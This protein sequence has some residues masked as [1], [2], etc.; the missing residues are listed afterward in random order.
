MS[1]PTST[2]ERA[3]S[4]VE[5]A[6][7]ESRALRGGLAESIAGGAEHFEGDDKTLLKFHGIYEQYDRDAKERVENRRHQYMVRV[8]IPGGALTAEQYLAL[9]RLADRFGGANLRLTSR[10]GVQFHGL[11]LAEL[12]PALRELD[13]SLLTTLA[14]C[15]D[16]RRNVVACPAPLDDAAHRQAQATARAIAE[17]LRPR[18]GAYHQIWLDGERVRFDDPAADLG[19][20]D[21]E[22]F[23][24]ETY[25]PRKFKIGVALENDNCIDLYTQDA[26]LLGLVE[27]GQVIGWNVVA[28]GGLGITHG[29]SDTFARLA[30][31]IGFV[32]FERGVE[33]IHAVAEVFRDHGDRSDRKRARLKYV[34]ERWGVER[35]RAEVQARIGFPLEDPRPVRAGEQEDH[36]GI[37]SQHAEEKLFFLG[38]YV[39][40]GRV[41]DLPGR[42]LRTAVREVVE[43]FRPGVRLTAQQSLLFTDLSRSEIAAV[44]GLLAERGVVAAKELSP[45]RRGS[46]ACPALPTCSLALAD[47]E[48][49][50]PQSLDEL[51]REFARLGIDDLPLTVRITGCPNGCARPYNADIGFVGRKPGV[52]HV[53]VGGGLAGDRLADLYAAD[54]GLADFVDVLRPLLEAYR[55]DRQAEESLSDFWQRRA[56]QLAPPAQNA[57]RAPRQLLTG[58]EPVA[59][60]SVLLANE[61]LAGARS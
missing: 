8:A 9:D 11:L 25:L 22:P 13:A 21:A 41:V 56:A 35:F 36:L 57:P 31:T 44:E 30:S 38:V 17:D 20:N 4:K 37:H 19:D 29:K 1:E 61:R 60:F 27:D 10:Q 45:V 49:V 48:R 28:G 7:R 55:E 26:G 53:Y 32:P 39:E 24:G 59:A 42:A 16:V 46:L 58:R 52:Y 50:L 12:Q 33:A 23:Y 34:I 2:P 40:S 43:R 51:E 54:V 15:G 6:K 3:E 14:A 18:T 47:A 5:I